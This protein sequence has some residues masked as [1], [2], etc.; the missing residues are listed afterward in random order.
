M[1]ELSLRRLSLTL[2]FLFSA[3]VGAPGT[4][5]Q[6]S[7]PFLEDQTDDEKADTGYQNPDGIEVEVDLEAD[8]VAAG[9]ALADAPAQLGQFALT[10]LRKRG[11]FYLES[12]AETA[13]SSD[14]VEWLVD[15]NWVSAKDVMALDDAKLSHFRIRGVNAVLLLDDAEGIEVG[16]VRTATVPVRPL[17]IMRDAGKHCAEPDNHIG[18]DQAVYWYLWDPDRND[19]KVEVQKMTV[20]V[21]NL[22]P[23]GHNTYPEYDRLVADKKITTVIFFGQIDDDPLSDN[24]AGMTEM[25]D[26]AEWLREAK[27]KEVANAPIGQRFAKKIAK[28]TF[29]YDLYSP[30]DFAGLGDT[31][32]F[33][34]FQKALA[35]HEI[36]VW[37]GHS[38]LGA[39]DFW[40]KP[41]Y[42]SFYQIFIYGGCLGYEYYVRP[43]LAGKDGWDNVDIISSVVEVS[44]GARDFAAP[45][46]ARL[47]WAVGH[48]YR[49]TWQSMLKA[50]RARVGDST[51]GVSGVRDNCFTPTGTRCQQEDF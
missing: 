21:S 35:E 28:V 38:M 49:V 39:S 47:Q 25:R 9:Y 8:V 24:D 42:P 30:Y 3:C 17:S 51:F 4:P 23:E 46:F 10:Y 20:T 43:I 16:T 27:F 36:V 13:G 37:D 1:S 45:F 48:G 18:L 32:H 14:R 2:P 31:E 33:D 19:C 29:E 41:K 40:T 22:L 11:D 44:A 12:L 50:I 26:F 5:S 34:N 6:A 7:N 15:G